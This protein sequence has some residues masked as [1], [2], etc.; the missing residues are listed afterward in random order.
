MSTKARILLSTIASQFILLTSLSSF[1][2]GENQDSVR[3]LD[4]NLYGFKKE[5]LTHLRVTATISMARI[6]PVMVSKLVILSTL[7]SPLAILH[8]TEENQGFVRSLDR[9]LY[10]FKKEKLTHFRVYWHDLYSGSSPT[11]MPIVRPPS[12]TS[13]TLFGS[14]SM[15]DDPLTEKPELS[16]K[17][18]GRAQGFYGS[19][20]Q[21]D[22]ALFMAMN[23]VFLEGKYNGSTISILGRNHVFSKEREMPVIG[24]SG[25]FRFARGYALANTFSFN[26]KTGDAVVE[27]SFRHTQVEILHHHLT[28]IF[29]QN[30]SIPRP[31]SMARVPIF[32][33]KFIIVSLIFSFA[34]ISVHGDQDHE[35]VRSMDRKLLGLKKEK[36]SHFKVYWHDILTGPNPSSIEVVPP[37]NTSVTAFGLVRMIDN[38]LTLGPE[39]SSKMVG[40]A[41]GFYAQASQ[42]DLGL[43][44]AMNFAFIEGKYNGSTVTVLGR[45]QVFST[46][47]EMPVIG[48]SGLFRFARGYVQARTHKVDLNTG[49]ATVEYN[50]Y[51][52]HY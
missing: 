52:F 48:G 40:K 37:M 45:N 30:L 2:T 21:E 17:L 32:A 23:F 44:M 6:V 24:G 1:V 7:L 15:I 19:A 33:P 25:L 42:Q 14:M 13:A 3:T 8:A 9:K 22:T 51:V 10:G 31:Y 20:G 4:R 41:Q 34:T 38:P 49:D 27:R 12:N 35:F 39:M 16:S 18:I 26:T 28:I 47:R 11:A 36:L 5:K 29:S 46:V 50:V 43:L